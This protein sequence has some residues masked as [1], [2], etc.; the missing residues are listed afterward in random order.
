MK[1]TIAFMLIIA[2]L[3]FSASCASCAE[4]S[5]CLRCEISGSFDTKT[6]TAECAAV[7]G[8]PAVII[9]A[10]PDQIM[11]LDPLFSSVI[12]SQEPFSCLKPA[13]LRQAVKRVEDVFFTWLK[14]QPAEHSKGLYSGDLFTRAYARSISVFRLEDFTRYLHDEISLYKKTDID[15]DDQ[16][17][18]ILLYTF[19]QL[20]QKG[21]EENL[22]VQALQF[23]D[24]KYIT[25]NIMR[26]N[27][28]VMTLSM[29]F[30]EQNSRKMVC[31]F[32]EN[33]NIRTIESEYVSSVEQVS[34]QRKHYVSD[35]AASL[36]S[37]RKKLLYADKTEI[38][39]IDQEKSEFLYQFEADELKNP[40]TVTAEIGK[41][42]IKAKGR[43]TDY[44][45]L[46]LDMDLS[47][48]SN[49]SDS[50]L[51]SM[52][53][54]KAYPDDPDLIRQMIWTGMIPVLNDILLYMPDEYQQLL[55][56]W[57]NE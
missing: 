19:A 18:V 55:L 24:G 52:D 37:V 25:M 48:L 49:V 45:K 42:S 50:S 22:L 30:T 2:C 56:S 47:V 43:I 8:R 20:C 44:E 3:L 10:C 13:N 14:K 57:I 51:M 29:D 38:K 40:F 46:R 17:Y 21:G 6:I 26:N 7:D 32:R 28:T 33:E 11:L 9:S 41:D 27:T 39:T 53:T 4:S 1:R 15:S 36:V 54:E 5:I 31:A 35:H 23:D 34:L 16:A 12:S